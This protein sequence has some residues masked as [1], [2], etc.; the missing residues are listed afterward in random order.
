MFMLVTLLVFVSFFF[1]KQKTAYAMRISDWSSDLC[2]SDLSTSTESFKASSKSALKNAPCWRDP[3]ELTRGDYGTYPRTNGA[4]RG[5]R[6]DRKSVVEGKSV[7]VSVD[8]GGSRS[9]KK[10]KKNS[11][12]NGQT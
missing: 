7:S 8:L 10:K 5:T 9:I 2:S 1:V 6:T 11:S 12:H 3:P 4:T